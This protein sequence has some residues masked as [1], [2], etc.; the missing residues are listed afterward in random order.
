M[1]RIAAWSRLGRAV[2]EDLA[3]YTAPEML[4][5]G[6]D[7]IGAGNYERLSKIAEEIAGAALLVGAARSCSRFF[8]FI[9]GD[10]V[11]SNRSIRC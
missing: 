10:S 8:S 11:L 5:S 3:S 4:K 7:A 6:I 1:R 9:F 2:A